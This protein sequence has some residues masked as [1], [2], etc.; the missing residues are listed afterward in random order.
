MKV[1]LYGA[2]GMIGQLALRE[3]LLDAE[4][5][6]VLAIVRK[7][8]TNHHPYQEVVFPDISDLSIVQDKVT[9]FDVCLCLIGVLSTGM[10]EAD[11]IYHL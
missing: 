11:Y 10:S 1:I 8:A 5:E 7:P 6:H 3:S 2:T 9:A 4:V